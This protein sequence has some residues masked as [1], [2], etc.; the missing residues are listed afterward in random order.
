VVYTP[1][2]DDDAHSDCVTIGSASDAEIAPVRDWLMKMLR[3][4]APAELAAL[5]AGCG[6]PIGPG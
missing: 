1:N 6:N 3:V 2:A 5:P 4:L